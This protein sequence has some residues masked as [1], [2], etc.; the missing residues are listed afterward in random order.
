MESPFFEYSRSRKVSFAYAPTPNH[1]TGFQ[2]LRKERKGEKKEKV[3]GQSVS[4]HRGCVI[5]FG[6]RIV[7]PARVGARLGFGLHVSAGLTDCEV[8][9]ITG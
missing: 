7:P 6:L 9:D 5:A 8:D 2:P 4:G 3:R 1:S